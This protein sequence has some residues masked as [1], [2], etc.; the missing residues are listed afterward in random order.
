MT[1]TATCQLT[2]ITATAVF[3]ELTQL[4]LLWPEICGPHFD[5]SADRDMPYL[6]SITHASLR[7]SSHEQYAAL[8]SGLRS[9][10][11][12]TVDTQ[13]VS[14]MYWAS[15]GLAIHRDLDTPELEQATLLLSA[16]LTLSVDPVSVTAIAAV[17]RARTR[18][19][20]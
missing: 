15:R 4:R 1:E 7:Y 2:P 10:P 6:R 20:N 17:L 16:L 5:I 11:T 19:P 8:A 13:Y 14:A 3:D 9:M 12:W 18:A